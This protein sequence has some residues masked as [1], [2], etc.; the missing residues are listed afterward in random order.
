ME[1]ISFFINWWTIALVL[2]ALE[3][4]TG[5]FFLLV[6][7][8]ASLV[9]G[10]AWLM[11]ASLPAQMIAASIA[12]VGGLMLRY[13]LAHRNKDAKR[14]GLSTLGESLLEINNSVMVESW[15]GEGIH[16]SAEV[17][18]RGATWQV[19]PA[20]ADTPLYEGA[21]FIDGVNGS[22]LLLRAPEARHESAVGR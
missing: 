7:A 18:Y 9:G 11:D 8:A 20:S 10:I 12:G 22:R 16:A 2:F 14:N 17:R 15:N 6:L 3:M 19:S 1:N 13:W 21:Y 4:F 5:T